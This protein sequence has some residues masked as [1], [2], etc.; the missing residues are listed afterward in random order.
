[1]KAN[2]FLFL[3]PL[4]LCS[5]CA[6]DGTSTLIGTDA[7]TDATL[8]D[9][10][11]ATADGS[12]E[13]PVTFGGERPVRLQVPSTYDS[14]LSYPL[15]V[16]LHG[17]TATAELQLLYTR[18]DTLVEAEGVLLLAPEGTRDAANNQFWNA[19]DYCCNFAG[20]DVDDSA[21]VRA[22]IG[23]VSEV[24]NV[25]ANRIYLWGHSNGGFMSYRMAC[26]HADK[27]AALVSLAGATFK[28]ERDCTPSE[29]VSILQ[30]HGTADATI[31][32]DGTSLYPG[33]KETTQ[34]WAM[35]NGCS[36]EAAA[37]EPLDL[38]PVT[39]N[40]ETQVERYSGCAS[41]STVE[42]WSIEDGPHIPGLPS[43]FAARMWQWFEAHPKG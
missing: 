4:V 43:D 25:D 21:Y 30:I 5:G 22:L 14:S 9:G 13:L 8:A 31:L 42:L 1:M 26:D 32:Y 3:A 18:L 38:V 16:V 34:T 39:E 37:G 6:D 41:G 27:I 35:Y 24:Y 11:I 12:A 23:D 33:A 17:Y 20:S 29:P 10:S 15:L 36:A 7:R 28:D 40:A 19:T 2:T